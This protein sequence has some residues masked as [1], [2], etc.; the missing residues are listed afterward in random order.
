MENGILL[1]YGMGN[2]ISQP[3]CT[4]GKYIFSASFPAERLLKL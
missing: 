1:F 4:G 2:V 3:L